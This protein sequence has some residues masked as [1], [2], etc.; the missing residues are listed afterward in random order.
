MSVGLY[1]G[2]LTTILRD[3]PFSGAYLMFYGGI[4]EFAKQSKKNLSFK[5]MDKAYIL[6]DPYLVVCLGLGK[7]ELSTSVIPICGLVSGVFASLVT[8]PPDVVKTAIQASTE[9]YQNLAIVKNIFKVTVF[10]SH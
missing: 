7:D 1:R 3:A 4:K 6:Q 9:P 8:H 2:S 5:L 10:R